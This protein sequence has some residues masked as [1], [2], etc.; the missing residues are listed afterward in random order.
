MVAGGR[1][2]L[3]FSH[4]AIMGLRGYAKSFPEKAGLEEGLKEII[5]VF[6]EI[7][8]GTGQFSKENKCL[9]LIHRQCSVSNF[10]AR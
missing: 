1:I 9:L 4:R 8:L 2:F 10:S 6:W 3:Y 7:S 5:Q